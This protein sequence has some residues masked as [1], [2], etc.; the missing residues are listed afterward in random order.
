[1]KVREKYEHNFPF[2][3]SWGGNLHQRFRSL[4]GTDLLRY[5]TQVKTLEHI[6]AKI[7]ANN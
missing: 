7:L 2:L 6:N 3:S 1:M 4:K 5:K